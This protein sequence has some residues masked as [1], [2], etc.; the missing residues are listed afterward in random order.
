MYVAAIVMSAKYKLWSN[1]NTSIVTFYKLIIIVQHVTFPIKR[2]FKI[3][4]I[5]IILNNYEY[6]VRL[7]S[8]LN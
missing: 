7:S 4:L 3:V 1:L 6:R 2:T 5:F 8:R